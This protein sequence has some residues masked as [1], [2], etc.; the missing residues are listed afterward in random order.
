MRLQSAPKLLGFSDLCGAC[1]MSEPADVVFVLMFYFITVFFCAPDVLR[2]SHL[3]ADIACGLDF[4]VS[5]VA[6]APVL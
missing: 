3:G 6:R 2:L 4:E 5:S 1:A